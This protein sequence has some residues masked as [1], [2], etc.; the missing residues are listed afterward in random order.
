MKAMV[1]MKTMLSK[2]PIL[3]SLAATMM[4]L[5]CTLSSPAASTAAPT[6]AASTTEP[7]R[8]P[9]P[10]ATRRI[11]TPTVRRPTQLIKPSATPSRTPRPSNTP[12]DTSTPAATATNTRPAATRGPDFLTTVARIK[13][14]MEIFGGIIDVALGGSGAVDCNEVVNTYN[15]V[16]GAPKMA[17][18][19]NLAGA[20]QLY[21]QGVDNFANKSKD[22]FLNCKNYLANNNS[23]DIP[24][25]QWGT[26]RQG[27]AESV[28]LLRSAIIAAGGTP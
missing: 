17:V 14:Q 24:Y 28:D 27:V 18:P 20:N 2:Q 10:T 4:L 23:G 25:Q 8:A 22:M 15:T 11:A 19:N 16:A 21:R 26:A 7:T 9:L 6:E 5:A 1:S 3:I 12:R 13:R